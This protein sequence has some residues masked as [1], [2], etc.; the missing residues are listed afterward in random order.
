[1][2]TEFPTREDLDL[3]RTRGTNTADGREEK[4]SVSLA[5]YSTTT[6]GKLTKSNYF[7]FLNLDLDDYSDIQMTPHQAK[8]ISSHLN[9]LSTGSHAMV[10]LSC[11][12]PSC[13]FASHCVLQKEGLAPLG[14]QCLPEVHL[15]KKYSV[16]YFEEFDVNPD[17]FTEVGY[18]SELAE[19]MI[20][21]MRLNM[22][23][24]RPE[25]ATLMI[26]EPVGADREGVP[27]YKLAISPM[28]E[29]K[30]KLSNRRMKIVKLMVGDRQEKYK[31]EAALK[32]RI[33]EDPSSK[34]ATMARE[35]G[36]LQ[37]NLTRMQDEAKTAT[38]S[39]ILTPEDLMSEDE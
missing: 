13:P 34:M 2:T 3:I 16:Q 4:E 20:L 39:K 29:L 19:L 7:R 14:R 6:S 9:K 26:D 28:I 10:P 35:L 22:N 5:G 8:R 11:S 18:I 30:E 25:N 32:L 36:S 23:L 37:R 15:L 21:E 1:M 17:N 12:G 24:A 38:F 33:D 27:I 31:K